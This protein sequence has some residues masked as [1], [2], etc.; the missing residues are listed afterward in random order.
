MEA[1]G[2]CWN[3]IMPRLIF[4]IG[5]I[6]FFSYSAIAQQPVWFSKI[7]ELKILTSNYQ[8]AIRVYGLTP[9]IELDEKIRKRHLLVI[10]SD[11]GA[12]TI[13]FKQGAPPCGRWRLSG[14]P[15]WNVTEGTVDLIEFVPAWDHVIHL[16]QLPFDTSGFDV[17]ET[18]KENSFI[19]ES[20]THGIS[21]EAGG[22]GSQKAVWRTY[23]YPPSS[24]EHMRCPHD[25]KLMYGGTNTPERFPVSVSAF[26]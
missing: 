25:M 9:S 11:A 8:D 12:T 20:K 22:E 19:Y 6:A 14:G 13:Y 17:I 15:G 23:F 3:L 26:Y 16:D 4:L 10:R 2:Y 21:V 7:K 5:V 18:A 1:S 24:M